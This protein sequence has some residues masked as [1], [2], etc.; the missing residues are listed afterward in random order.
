VNARKKLQR[1][2]AIEISRVAHARVRGCGPPMLV[3]SE[4]NETE[5]FQRK[6]H[7]YSL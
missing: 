6:L 3:H 7:F 2:A 1:G 4:N 5:D